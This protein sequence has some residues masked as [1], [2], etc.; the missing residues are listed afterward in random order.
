MELHHHLEIMSLLCLLLHYTI[1]KHIKTEIINFFVL[2][3]LNFYFF[4]YNFQRIIITK[5]RPV[6]I[7]HIVGVSEITFTISENVILK[8]TDLFLNTLQKLISFF[9]GILDL[10]KI[11]KIQFLLKKLKTKMKHKQSV[12]IIIG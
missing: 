7:Q 1:K 2:L 3:N 6:Y 9:K 10:L 5:I 4:L 11:K 8:N 12:I